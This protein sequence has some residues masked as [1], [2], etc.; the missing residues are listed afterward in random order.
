MSIIFKQAVWEEAVRRSLVAVRRAGSEQEVSHQV[1]ACCWNGSGSNHGA[2]K[3]EKLLQCVSWE[4]AAAA[5]GRWSTDTASPPLFASKSVPA[6]KASS[7]FC[8]NTADKV[9]SSHRNSRGTEWQLETVPCSSA[10]VAVPSCWTAPA[11]RVG[12]H[13]RHPAPEAAALRG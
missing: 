5:V 13:G 2:E 3:E 11:L 1:S 12:G 6:M 4:E 10:M 7:F 9:A 8:S